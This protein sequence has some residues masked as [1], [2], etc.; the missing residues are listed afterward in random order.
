MLPIG[1]ERRPSE[2]AVT[3]PNLV[4]HGD[5]NGE[6]QSAPALDSYPAVSERETAGE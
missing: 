4:Q 3:V 2:R 6:G 5:S 1:R